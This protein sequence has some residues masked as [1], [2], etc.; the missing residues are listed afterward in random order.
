MKYN[1]FL[2]ALN[3]YLFGDVFKKDSPTLI[4]MVYS[5]L[6]CEIA[7]LGFTT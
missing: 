7:Y 4:S 3:K 2:D 6:G 5:F 1:M